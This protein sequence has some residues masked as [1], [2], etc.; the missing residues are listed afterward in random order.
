MPQEPVGALVWDTISG[1]FAPV[2]AVAYGQ[3]GQLYYALAPREGEEDATME[4]AM[5]REVCSGA[6]YPC[7]TRWRPES[8]VRTA[9]RPARAVR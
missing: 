4:D 5:L 6:M 9:K 2:A 8:L 3:Q 1:N 7:R